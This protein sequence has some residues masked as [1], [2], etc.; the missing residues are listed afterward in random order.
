MK[1]P[2]RIAEFYNFSRIET[3]ILEDSELFV[4]GT[5]ATTD[6]VQKQMY[7]FKTKGGDDLTLRPE[8]HAVDRE[9]LSCRTAWPIGLSR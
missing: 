2:R 4:K 8:G 9:V 1:P 3:P 6:I 5:G 7:S